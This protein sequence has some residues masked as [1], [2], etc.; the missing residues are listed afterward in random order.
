MKHGRNRGAE[1]GRRAWPSPQPVSSVPPHAAPSPRQQP[2]VVQDERGISNLHPQ[3]QQRAG[4][5]G[6]RDALEKTDASCESGIV[7]SRARARE[8]RLPSL[9]EAASSTFWGSWG[10]PGS[11]M[12]TRGRASQPAGS[13]PG[14]HHLC[15]PAD[16]VC[17]GC[18]PEAPVLQPERVSSPPQTTRVSLRATPTGPPHPRD[19]RRV[20]DS[21]GP[22]GRP[23]TAHGEGCVSP[24]SAQGGGRAGKRAKV[25]SG[26]SLGR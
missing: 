18:W 17:G 13:S 22:G 5:R 6:S 7:S 15:S 1:C 20:P 24:L 8:G 9:P 19:E 10:G 25:N 14:P 16:H 23:R 3:L 11:V 4:L 21:S 2:R 12:C 26:Q